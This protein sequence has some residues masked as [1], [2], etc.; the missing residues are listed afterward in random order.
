MKIKLTKSSLLRK[1]F[2]K[3]ILRGFMFLLCFSVF[4]LSTDNTVKYNQWSQTTQISG[5]VEDVNGQPLIGANILEKNTT[6]GTQTD[7]DGNFTIEV[8]SEDAILVVSYLG[9]STI[10]V[11]VKGQ[12]ELKI[13]LEENASSLDEIVVTALGIKREEKSLGYAVSQIQ[14]QSIR[15]SSET[16]I[17][18][19]LSGKVAGVT[20]NT[21]SG[22]VDA[23]SNIVIRGQ[24]SLRGNNQPLFVIDGVQIDNNPVAINADFG[25]DFGNNISDINPDDIETL[26]VLKGPNAAALYGSRAA[27]GVVII[28]TKKGKRTKGLGLTF[29]STMLTEQAYDILPLQDEFGSGEGPRFTDGFFGTNGDGIPVLGIAWNNFGPRMDGTTVIGFSGEARPYSPQ[30]NNIQDFYRTGY[31]VINN[32]AFSGSNDDASSTYRISFT[33]RKREGTIERNESDKYTVNFRGTQKITD[34]LNADVSMSYNKSRGQGRPIIG[35]GPLINRYAGFF[36]RDMPS[37]IYRDL[38]KQDDGSRTG[39]CPWCFTNSY[40]EIFE[41]NN[42]DESNRLIGTIDLNFTI[43]D[44][45]NL[46][47][48]AS[49]DGLE[50]Y[51]ENSSSGSLIGGTGPDASFATDQQ[52]TKQYTYEFLLSAQRELSEDLDLAINIGGQSWESNFK[53]IS[54]STRNGLRTPGFFSISNSNLDPLGSAF[55]SNRKINSLYGFGQLGFK[56]YLFLDFTA[57]NDWSSTLPIKNNSYFYPSASLSFIF[58]DALD[59]DSSILTFGKLRASWAQV[60]NDAQGAYL[61]N[62]V[63]TSTGTFGSI[64]LSSTTTSVPPG[65]L[66]PEKTNSTE[67]GLDLRFF[68]NR[69]GIDFN[70]YKSTTSNQIIELDVAE[71]SGATRALVNAGEIE[72]K[73]V[74]LLLRG[75][76]I[77]TNHFNWDAS[78]NFSK[79]KNKVIELSGLESISLTRNNDGPIVVEAR[80][81]KPYGDIVTWVPERD[82]NGNIIVNDNGHYANNFERKVVGNIQPDW[83]GGLTNTFT[84][85]GFTLNS[86]IDFSVGGEYYSYNKRWLTAR[87]SSIE[88]LFGRDSEHGGLAWVD[89]NGRSRNDGIIAD[90]VTRDGSPNAVIVSATAFYNNSY[91]NNFPEHILD[92]SYV[93]L[94]ELSLS[95]RIPEKLLKDSFIR[96]ANISLIGR[97]LAILSNSSKINNPIATAYGSG[98]GSQGIESGSFAPS[99]LYGLSLNVSF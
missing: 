9:F 14:G 46:K 70:W 91:Q 74:E 76:P 40:W 57:R 56:D 89:G 41:K 72:N 54:A 27:N 48:K 15:E 16:N 73:G 45:I 71:S 35:N 25:R 11:G 18:N 31:S 88:S 84:Y 3:N 62:S 77:K 32:V 1:R 34:Y 68:K 99:R 38:Y 86:L 22:G 96:N 87:G 39:A 65:N 49:T 12:T 24:N 93:M 64:P 23:S 44:W 85:K 19:A 92:A 29:S 79:N 61:L 2:L 42:I 36:P 90:G 58:S 75:T 94:R 53:S 78:F 21:S 33:S 47:L 60:G 66:L 28:T 69:L 4:S 83:T 50:R 30:P 37:N 13:V 97:N 7:F 6:N 8:N 10:E 95:Y 20:I 17:I 43:T 51:F 63:Y 80:P 26:S 82:A 98:N 55:F 67:I 5:K 81:G 52:I 59:I